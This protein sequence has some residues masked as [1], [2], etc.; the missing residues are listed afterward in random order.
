MSVHAASPPSDTPL[1]LDADIEPLA[2]QSRDLFVGRTHELRRLEAALAETLS[3]RGRLTLLVGERGI[4][5][6]RAAAE[7]AKIAPRAAGV[8][9]SGPC[10]DAEW[11]PPFGPFAEA[12]AVPTQLR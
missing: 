8:V 3:G 11:A 10:Y 6:T 7:F 12:I 9:L 1:R 4:G 5:K 2:H